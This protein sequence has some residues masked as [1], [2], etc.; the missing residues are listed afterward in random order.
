[1]PKRFAE[2]TEKQYLG[3]S[4]GKVAGRPA[5]IVPFYHAIEGLAIHAK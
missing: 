2:T 1:M 5:D 3:Y 4:G